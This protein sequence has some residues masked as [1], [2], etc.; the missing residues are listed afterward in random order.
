MKKMATWCVWQC[1]YVIAVLIRKLIQIEK[2][3][4]DYLLPLDDDQL[5][6]E[7]FMDMY[8][9]TQKNVLPFKKKA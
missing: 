6:R 3:L 2:R 9:E 4:I 5:S 8:T 1:I 7:I